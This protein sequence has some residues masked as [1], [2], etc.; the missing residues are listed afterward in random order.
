MKHWQVLI[1]LALIYSTNCSAQ[2]TAKDN[3]TGTW[4][5]TSICQVKSSPCHDENVVYHISTAGNS[6]NYSIQASK[7]VNS[8]EDDLGT[9]AASYDETQHT[10]TVTM[11]DKRSSVWLFKIDG[12]Q[13][14]GTLTVDGKILYRLIELKKVD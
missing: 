11:K 2:E 7:I 4:K 6:K 13:M 8:V 9:L 12:K 5:G 10:L 1:M 14:H 3:I